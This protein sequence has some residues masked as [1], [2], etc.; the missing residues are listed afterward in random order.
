MAGHKDHESFNKLSRKLE[1]MVP[2]EKAT[3]EE[4]SF[5]TVEGHRIAYSRSNPDL[6]WAIFSSILV[7][8]MLAGAITFAVIVFMALYSKRLAK[9]KWL[10]TKVKT[11]E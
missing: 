1:R 11:T 4:V 2:K 8:T 6:F 7:S 5:I 3:F 10:S 9:R